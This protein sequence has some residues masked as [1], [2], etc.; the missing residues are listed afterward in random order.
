MSRDYVMGLMK[1]LKFVAIPKAYD[2][3]LATARK[4]KQTTETVI[5]Q[6]FEIEVSERQAR[7]IRYRMTQARFPVS[8]DLD[9]FEFDKLS[10]E[11]TQIKEPLRWRLYRGTPQH[12]FCRRHGYR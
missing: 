8:K 11:E 9:S 2:E 12:C 1:S 4:R 10:V 3:V 5:E 7:S 6:L